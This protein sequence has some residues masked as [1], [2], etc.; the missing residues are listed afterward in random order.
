VFLSVIWYLGG[1][2]VA[3]GALCVIRPIRWLRLPT[4]KRAA[5]TALAGFVLA[6]AT[7]F[8][9][10]STHRIETPASRLDRVIPAFEFNE[11]HSIRI[12]A[13]AD[14]VYRAVFEVTADEIAGYRVLTWIRCLGR[15]PEGNLMNPSAR[16]PLLAAALSSG[17]RKLAETPN[18]ELV[19][20]TF[21][22]APADAARREWTLEAFVAVAEPGYAK[23]VMNFRLQP[24]GSGVTILD[25]ETRVH[26][27][28][29]ATVR[30]FAAYWRTILPGS[31]LIRVAWLRAIKR[32]AEG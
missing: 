5:L 23:A 7:L 24:A 19:F 20:G 8:V 25:T 3:I 11:H 32:R 27:T 4:R 30:T 31:A 28:D 18:E 2:L 9:G 15:C 16:S 1:T 26:A 22:A 12:A 13:P 29:P 17:F 6:Q 21:V 14:R 10:T